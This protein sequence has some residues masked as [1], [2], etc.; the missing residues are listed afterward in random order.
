MNQQMLAIYLPLLAP[1]ATLAVV[2]VGFL[3]NNSRL[4]DFRSGIG[5]LRAEFVDLRT[6]VRGSI[7]NLRTEVRGSIENLRTEFR[8]NVDDLRTELRDSVGDLR[9]SIGDIRGGMNDMRDMLRAEMRV[10]Q[11]TM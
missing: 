1:L 9:G 10:L 4:S 11:T 5:D 8:G 3:Y 2:M 6:E 7:E